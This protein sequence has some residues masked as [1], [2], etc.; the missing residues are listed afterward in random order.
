[1][2]TRTGF[3]YRTGGEPAEAEV[4][5]I[6]EQLPVAPPEEAVVLG[7]RELFGRLATTAML[8]SMREAFADWRPDFVLREPCEYASAV[9][10]KERGIATAQVAI[11]LAQHEDNSID[12]A[13][14]ALEAHR[15]DLVA[16]LRSSPYVTRFPGPLDPS[17]FPNTIRFHETRS[18]KPLP[19]WWQGSDAPLVY[20][21]FGTVLG[22]MTIAADVY[23]QAVD[24]LTDVPARVLLTVGR[25]FDSEQL[26]PVPDN[27]HVE[28]WVDQDDVLERADVV[29]CHGGSGTAFGAI[30]AGV[31]LVLVP[32]FAD[33]FGNSR[34]IAD[35]GAG[36]VVEAA[37]IQ[38]ALTN[39][40][41]E[42]RYRRHAE[43]LAE[44]IAATNNVDEA[45]AEVLGRGLD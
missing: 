19:D 24:A 39:V 2:V 29:V 5:P 18:P 42:P 45:L 12:A 22:H 17:P 36:V 33:Q 8:P 37:G 32:V 28:A 16:A 3:A 7:N 25:K 4:A 14:P 9:V 34:R 11:S 44:E 6:R 23:R 40:L 27:V 35:A 38:A 31:P 10:A 41:H 13:A 43:R 20:L 15:P 30:A 21:T 26:G 1:M